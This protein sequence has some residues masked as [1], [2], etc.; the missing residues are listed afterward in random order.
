V[1]QLAAALDTGLRRQDS[2]EAGRSAKVD[3]VEDLLGHSSIAVTERD[4]RKTL[5]RLKD[6]VKKLDDGQTFKILS[7]SDDEPTPLE[8]TS[9]IQ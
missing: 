4:D 9:P 8:S 6:A 7:S 2:L 3:D 5:N 1:R